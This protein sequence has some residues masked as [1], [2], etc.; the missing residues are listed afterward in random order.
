MRILLAEDDEIIADGLV[1]AFKR[2]GFAVDHVASGSDADVALASQN[3][4]LVVLDLGLPKLPGIEVLKRLRARKSTTPVL[5]LTA[6]DGIDDRVRGLDAGA[7][8]YL[9]KPFALPELEARVRAL[10]RRGTGQGSCIT[11]GALSYNQTDR[12]AQVDGQLIELSAREIGVLEILLLRVG[13]LVSKEQLVD[14]L[15]GWG[16][17]VSHNAIE[18]YV[19]RLRKKLEPSGLRIATVRGLGY[20][21]EKPDAPV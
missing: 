14:H 1:R 3:F 10:A 11:L 8:D 21:L 7:D 13:R 9:T 19:H 4:D 17:E 18:V 6:Q 2:G 12:A 16:E 15:C 5:I 20:C